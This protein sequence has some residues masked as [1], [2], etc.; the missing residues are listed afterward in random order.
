MTIL[1]EIFAHTKLETAA[2]K[3]RLPL[4]DLRRAAE[5]EPRPPD[6]VTVLLASRSERGRPAL[7][8]EVK[9]ASPSRGILAAKADPVGLATV[10]AENGAA[11]ISVLT[12]EKYFGGHLDFLRRI[13][14]AL[15]EMPL[16]RKD[17]VCDPY[18][19]YEA[20]QAGASAVLL[21]A[22]CLG[23]A[24]LADLHA[25]VLMSGMAALVEV[26]DSAELEAALSLADLRLLGVNNRDLKTF[27]VDLATCLGLRP[28][29]PAE[30]CFVAESGIRAAEDVQRLQAAGVDAILV[31]EA[32]VTAPDTAARV[33]SLS[34]GPA[35]GGSP[36]GTGKP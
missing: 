18:Q 36:R 5:A 3:R 10:Y 7:I 2:R 21:I 19:V 20:R 8:A 25:L 6:F 27:R 22:A 32:L 34:G 30:V 28:L 23:P 11:A 17:F 1:D 33:R 14:A 29:V 12:D 31:G 24:Q 9:F 15:P 26:H 13:H 4:A 16:L 35:P